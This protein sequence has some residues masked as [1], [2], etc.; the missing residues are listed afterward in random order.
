MKNKERNE[1]IRIA[2]LKR[3]YGDDYTMEQVEEHRREKNTEHLRNWRDKHRKHYSDYQNEY[4]QKFR[5]KDPTYYRDRHRWEK[6]VKD[7]TF[8]GT[9][10]E[11]RVWQASKE[12]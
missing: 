2:H 7:G 10:K 5:A 3:F 8:T 11:F 6:A 12:E 9:F 1:K 4:Q